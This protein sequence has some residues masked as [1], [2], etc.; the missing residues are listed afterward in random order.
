[1]LQSNFHEEDIAHIISIPI[2]LI[3]YEDRYVWHYD[4]QGGYSVKSGYRI[5]CQLNAYFP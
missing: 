3:N 4:H 1:M 5:A 2:R